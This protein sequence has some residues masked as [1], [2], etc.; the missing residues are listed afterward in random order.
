MNLQ[1]IVWDGKPI[2]KPGLYSGIPIDVYHSPTICV[3]PSISST[4]LRTIFTKSERHYW[5]SSPYN[6]DGEPKE[7]TE[8]MVLGQA[9]HHLFLGEEGFTKRFVMRPEEMLDPTTET[10]KPWHSNRTV[11]K[12]W[13]KNAAA[14]NLT[15]L[16]SQQI[17]QLRGMGRALREDA[18]V[19]TGLLGGLIE[20]SIFWRDVETGVW[21]KIRP[22]SIPTDGGD[23]ADLKVTS[24]VDDGDLESTIGTFYYPMQGGLIGLGFREVLNLEMQSFTLLFIEAKRPHCI[25]PVSIRPEDLATA[26]LHIRYA[27]RAFAHGI[28]SGDWPGPAGRSADAR[29]IAMKPWTVTM[30]SKRYEMLKRDHE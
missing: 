20:H 15:V 1:P 4:G 19:R 30:L 13:M 5:D 7:P 17:D 18:L 11:C 9:A 26:A 8:Y 3:G 28:R 2:S 12:T 16:T 21:I 24:S 22:D 25:V 14:A 29:Y 6:A 23:A 10:M 27:L